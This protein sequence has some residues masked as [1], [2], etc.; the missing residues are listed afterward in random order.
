MA[1]SSIEA[2]YKG[3]VNAAAEVVWLQSLLR[4]LG[5]PQSPLIV[6]CDNFGATYL[7]INHIRHS[8]SKYVEIDIHFVR[9]YVINGV[10]D[11][12][13]FSTKTN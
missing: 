4:E 10:L 2:E 13:L 1:R 9:D 8:R 5:V 3:V 12:R 6:L 7:S 11:V